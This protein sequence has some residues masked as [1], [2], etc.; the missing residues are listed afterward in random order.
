MNKD[1]LEEHVNKLS[2][3]R[4]DI[5]EHLVNLKKYANE[6]NSI[7]EMGVR[8][9]VSTWALLAGRPQKM[10]SY[11]IVHPK[12]LGANID[13]VYNT[14]EEIGV[15]YEFINASTL[16]IEIEE[17]DLL[18][19][20]TDHSYNQLSKELSLHGN[21]ANKY[22]IM[23]DTVTFGKRDAGTQ[24]NKEKTG[25]ITAIEEFLDNNKEW[26]IHKHYENNNGLMVLSRNVDIQ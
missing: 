15:S 22:I 11:D 16:D 14:A 3:T 5:N 6:C 13:S 7:T 23:H 4:S 10:I 12:K 8:T 9:I 21:K 2:K 26:E 1:Q 25:L 20:D 18:F 19:I 24:R 17:T